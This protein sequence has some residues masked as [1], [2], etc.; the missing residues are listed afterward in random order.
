LEGGLSIIPTSRGP[1]HAGPI[2]LSSDALDARDRFDVWREELMLRVVR[3]DVDVPDRKSFHTRLRV[4]ALPN[5]SIIERR[6]TPSTVR[7]TAEL[8]RD[9][10][11]ALVFTLPW[12]N[13]AELRG[14]G[15]QG[16]A[17]PGEAIVA[18]MDQATSLH[19]PNGFR[20]VSLRL[21][22]SAARSVASG[23]E[24]RL[25]QRIPLDPTGSALLRSYL[26]SLVSRGAGLSPSAAELADRQVRELLAHLFDPAGD[27][28]RAQTYGGLR[29]A[30]LRAVV[31]AIAAR[32]AD[33]DLS[34]ATL[35]RR[36]GLSERY[37]QQLL[38]GAGVSFSGYVRELRLK[39]AHQM[40][41]DPLTRHLR[42]GDIAAM[43]GFS[44][45]SHFNHTFR[46]R[47]GESPTDAR[48][49]R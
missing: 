35:G 45:L 37:V 18:S 46:Q 8:A 28:A 5:V 30:R 10:D 47:F 3:V 32:V 29:A 16:R 48:R 23:V 17:G 6:T 31:E 9:G 12:R 42:V 34:A 20:G 36:L 26:V 21:D 19:A 33:P 4:L 40:L 41:R 22:R 43:A 11:D 24:R 49:R 25:N 38:E 15:D 7:R 14:G 2:L 27:L 13:S 39:R 1:T 44:D